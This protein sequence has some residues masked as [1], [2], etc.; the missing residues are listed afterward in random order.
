M[1]A[2]AAIFNWI[3]FGA[4]PVACDDGT[5]GLLCR[6]PIGIGALMVDGALVWMLWMGIA[7]L[8]GRG[9]LSPASRRGRSGGS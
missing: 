1:G 6:G 8:L 2:F 3:A 5:T 9:R 7:R 4:G